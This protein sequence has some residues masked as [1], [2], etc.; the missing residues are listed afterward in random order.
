MTIEIRGIGIDRALTARVSRQMDAAL[1]PIRVKPV[2]AQVSF[3]DDNGPKGGPAIRCALTVRLPYRPTIR[4]EDIAET[5]RLAFDGAIKILERQL[6][7]YRERERDSRRRPKKYFVA[8]RLTEG[9][10][11]RKAPRG[12]Q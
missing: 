6:E 11:A 8:K 12:S 3:F 10:P 2:G 5:P 1:D 7:R 4:I 9:A